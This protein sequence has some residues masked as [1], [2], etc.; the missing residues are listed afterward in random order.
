MAQDGLLIIDKP[1]GPTS[2]DVV[3]RIRKAL[4]MRRVGHGGTLDPD[5]TGVLLVAAGQATR[6]FP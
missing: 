6:F 2:H 1:P 4:A 3:Q 5:A